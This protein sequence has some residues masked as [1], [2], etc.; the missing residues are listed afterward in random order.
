LKLAVTFVAV[1][2]FDFMW[3]FLFWFCE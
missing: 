3:V 2:F 1:D